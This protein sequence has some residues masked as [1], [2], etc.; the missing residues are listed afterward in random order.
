[1]RSRRRS[2]RWWSATRG[3]GDRG[4]AAG[5][6]APAASASLDYIRAGQ[7]GGRPNGRSAAAAARGA[8]R[9]WY[10]RPTLFAD[11]D[12]AMRIAREE[13]FGPVLTCCRTATR[14]EAVRIANDSDYGLGGMRLDGGRRARPGDRRDRSARAPTA[15][16]PTAWTPPLRSAAS[17]QSGIGREF[18]A[19][20]LTEYVEIQ[21][22]ISADKLPGLD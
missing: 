22:T 12:N 20:G 16:T 4:R 10:V 3:P 2:A 21:T 1:M 6:P 9:G 5:G 8:E 11:V 7:R 18:G 14:R 19:E 15:S 17:R 13:I